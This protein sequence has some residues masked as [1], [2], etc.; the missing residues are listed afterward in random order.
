MHK[1]SPHDK[2]TGA[3][4][5]RQT[6]HTARQPGLHKGD[7]PKSINELLVNRSGLQRI[8]ASIPLQQSWADWLRAAVGS[9]L[10]GHIVN[11][12]PKA[13][14]LVVFADSAVWATRLRYTLA[15]MQPD[16]AARDSAI[17]RITVRVQR[18]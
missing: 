8:S 2:K 3:R 5:H 1:K 10:A 16:I 15:A 9:S 7:K 18:Q 17:A 14:E 12:V 4:I 13:A 11:A 6:P